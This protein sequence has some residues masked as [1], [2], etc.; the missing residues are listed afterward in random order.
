MNRCLAFI[1]ALLFAFISISSA[2]TAAS[3][4]WLHFTLE[5]SHSPRGDVHASFRKE[6]LGRDE[7]DWSTDL[8]A[9][10]LVGL[11]VA[12]F[13]ASGT[14]PLRFSVIREAGRLDCAGQG[15]NSFAGGNC[16]FIADPGFA[17][18]LVDRRIG[19]PTE[20]QALALMAVNARRELVDTLAGAGY[21]MP[22]IENL[23]AL[24]ALNV[25]GAY[26]TGLSHAGY[27]PESIESLIEFKA[28]GITPEWTAGFVRIGYA[29]VP[30]EQLVQ[31]KALN[32]TPD[33]IAGFDRIGYRHLPVE[34][35]VQ[36]KAMNITPDFVTR[37]AAVDNGLPPVE[38]LVELKAF[39]RRR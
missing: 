11:D 3:A 17:Q 29:N 21:P 10:E 38:K 1:A 5:P 37:V 27:R 18:L 31:L 26:I 28:L 2:C 12:G 30:A 9:P 22:N 20:N 8:G 36:L 33:F 34:Q 19:R 13:R 16:S 23:I 25:S 14:H 32:I 15:G 7:N 35:L 4:D 6:T 39:D 24:S